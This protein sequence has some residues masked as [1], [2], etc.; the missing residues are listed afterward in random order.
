MGLSGGGYAFFL[1]LSITD[2]IDRVAK[3]CRIQM[4]DGM[5][6]AGLVFDLLVAG[7][8]GPAGLVRVQPLEFPRRWSDS[9]LTR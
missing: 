2:F 6:L 3:V 5:R 8:F 9:R 1:S 7:L 4:S